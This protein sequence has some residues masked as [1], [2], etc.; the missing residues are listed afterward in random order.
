MKFD[1]QIVAIAA[2]R[3]ASAIYS[4][5]ADIKTAAAR[6]GIPVHS[7]DSLDIPQSAKQRPFPFEPES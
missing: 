3:Q 2:S 5:D 4:D 1:W 6:V 7:T